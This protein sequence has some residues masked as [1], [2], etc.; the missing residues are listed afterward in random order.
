L[1]AQ[2]SDVSFLEEIVVTAT[3]REERLIDVPMSMSA[4]DEDSLTRI[5]ADNFEGFVGQVPGLAQNSNGA[6][7]SKFSI[8]GVTTSMNQ[9]NT[10]APVA[11]YQDDL[12]V[13]DSFASL[14]TPDLRLFDVNRVE[15]LRGPQGTLFGSGALGGA[16]RIIT[17]KPDA[18]SFAA[19]LA[20]SVSTVDGGDESFGINGMVNVPLIEDKLALR[21]VIYS[22]DDGGY[23]DNPTRG[24]TNVDSQDSIGGRVMLG[25]DATENLSILLS[26]SAQDDEPNDRAFSRVGGPNDV[27]DSVIKEP[28]LFDSTTQ[29]LTIDYDFGSAELTSSTTFSDRSEDLRSDASGALGPVAAQFG[30]P[31]VVGIRSASESEVFA[32]EFRLTSKSDSSF[33]WIVGA[34]YRDSERDSTEDAT[35]AGLDAVLTLL[36][37]P[38]AGSPYPE[39][40][41]FGSVLT[42]DTTETAV[43]GE[44]TYDFNDTLSA[45]LGA[46]WFEND[47]NLVTMTGGP[48]G[49][50]QPPTARGT[51]ESE[52][53]PKFSL[54]YRPNEITHYYLTV[55]QGYRVGQSN[56]QLPVIPGIPESPAD[57]DA[58]SL[59][60]YEIGTKVSALSGRL[61]IEAAAFYIDWK[62]IQLT[63]TNPV[64]FA[65]ISNAGDATSKGAELSLNYAPN[66]NWTMGTA[67]AHTKTKIE[68]VAPGALA[69]VG[70]ELPGAAEWKTST[71]L[72]WNHDIRPDVEGYVRVDHQYMSDSFNLLNNATSPKTDDYSLLNLHLGADFG[73]W[74]LALYG[75]NLTDTHDIVNFLIGLNGITAVRL[76]PREFGISLRANF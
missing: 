64:G 47:Q 45:T 16:I 44:F 28:L 75:K 42:I 55:A 52:V 14:A 63:Q 26:V 21:A 49:A 60:N 10:Q 2:D 36:G 27:Y 23:V 48:L 15:V 32:Q 34:F 38:I 18:S 69:T 25:W 5:S 73:S 7:A 68:S 76:R 72:Q 8:R 29:N 57:Y 41:L 50:G 39:D 53:T 61:S 22:R 37:L 62:D 24:E 30:L 40:A 6:N 35:T 4:L 71:H 20:A 51:T 56:F 31:P 33:K 19:T 13:L 58:D 54:S 12:P 43:F 70:D 3:K 46:R 17:N 1:Q 74:G 11:V 66:Q 65:F 9:G 67:I 59:W